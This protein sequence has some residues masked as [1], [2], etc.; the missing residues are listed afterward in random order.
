MKI[1]FK[2]VERFV[3]AHLNPHPA[4]VAPG[5]I[6]L[7][8][9]YLIEVASFLE[10]VANYAQ[11]GNA[12]VLVKH[13]MDPFFL[14]HSVLNSGLPMWTE[15]IS[16]RFNLEYTSLDVNEA[17][18]PMEKKAPHV[19]ASS[20]WAA[21]NFHYNKQYADVSPF[22]PS[23]PFYKTLPFVST[24]DPSYIQ[25]TPSPR[26]PTQRITSTSDPS[27]IILPS[28]ISP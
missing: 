1:V 18:W 13:T 11:T 7:N 4:G 3:L 27:C 10:R 28:F 25:N 2:T 12:R 5:S 8:L 17:M 14:A 15:L 24:S 6:P 21:I 23:S 22:R 26:P 19:P 20:A 16:P 9:C